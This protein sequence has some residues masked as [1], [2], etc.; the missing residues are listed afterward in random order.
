MP[1]CQVLVTFE[2]DNVSELIAPEDMQWSLDIRDPQEPDECRKGV[3]FSS[4]DEV[5]SSNYV[6]EKKDITS[7]FVC[8]LGSRK[9][10]CTID[11]VK[12]RSPGSCSVTDNEPVELVCFETKRVDIIKF[13]FMKGYT[14]VSSSG[15]VFEDVDISHE[16]CDYDEKLGA[17]V[18]LNLTNVELKFSKDLKA[19][20]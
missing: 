11:V 4:V 19:L 6:N 7:N 10:L 1:Y 8:A 3:V 2:A 17:P 20:K 18:S 14:I 5:Q 15:T 12:S 16:W 13:N 9:Q